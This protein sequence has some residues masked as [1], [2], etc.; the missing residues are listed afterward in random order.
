[1]QWQLNLDN[2]TGFQ[3]KDHPQ[4]AIMVMLQKHWWCSMHGFLHDMHLQVIEIVFHL[5]LL[6][7]L[8]YIWH[9]GAAPTRWHLALPCQITDMDDEAQMAATMTASLQQQCSAIACCM[10][11]QMM[12]FPLQQMMKQLWLDA[13]RRELGWQWQWWQNQHSQGP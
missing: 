4:S 8:L 12:D 6:L 5:M 11:P 10:L 13:L 1:M 3:C 7:C 9:T 2:Q